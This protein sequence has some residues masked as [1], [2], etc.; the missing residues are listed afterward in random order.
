MLCRCAA[1]TH[2]MLKPCSATKPP[3]CF[4][5]VAEICAAGSHIV[6]RTCSAARAPACCA[7]VAEHCAGAQDGAKHLLRRRCCDVLEGCVFCDQAAEHQA[8]VQAHEQRVRMC[9]PTI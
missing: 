9:V 8:L 2:D 5:K 3:Q 6:W 4:V 1:G 7:E